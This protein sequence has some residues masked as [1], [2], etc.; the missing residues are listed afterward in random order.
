VGPGF[1]YNPGKADMGR[2]YSQA[3]LERLKA[4]GEWKEWTSLT[5][6]DWQD[7]GRPARVPADT[8][9]AGAGK[10]LQG[11]DDI[12][13]ELE[14]ILG[15]KE[16]VFTLPDGSSVLVN[17]EILARHL[18]LDRASFLPFLPE[19]LEDPFEIWMEFMRHGATGKVALRKRLVKVVEL[20]SNKALILIAESK[21]GR[22]V[23]WTFIPMGKERK[24]AALR[25]GKLVWGR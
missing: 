4:A 23:G 22:F 16:K 25:K 24:L 7:H 9:K 12:G 19:V 3:D 5:K 14:R 18:P 15:G 8:P 11:R 1:A 2:L 13:R 17:A 10:A 6:G 21:G 20:S